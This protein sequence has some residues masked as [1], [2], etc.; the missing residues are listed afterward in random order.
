MKQ[1]R[2]TSD[3]S[4]FL[5]A[6]SRGRH[7]EVEWLDDIFGADENWES[8]RT[9]RKSILLEADSKPRR[10]RVT[11]GLSRESRELLEGIAPESPLVRRMLDSQPP[12]SRNSATRRS[13]RKASK[14]PQRILSP[15]DQLQDSAAVDIESDQNSSEGSSLGKFGRVIPR[16]DERGER[17]RRKLKRLRDQVRERRKQSGRKNRVAEYFID[18]TSHPSDLFET[19]GTQIS[20]QRNRRSRKQ[21]AQRKDRADA[22]S[23]TT[24]PEFSDDAS[25]IAGAYTVLQIDSDTK[26]E[27]ESYRDWF[28]RVIIRSRWITWFTTF[29][30]HWVLL[31]LLG[32]IIINVPEESGLGLLDGSFTPTEPH[33]LEPLEPEPFE[34]ELPPVDEVPEPLTPVAQLAPETFTEAITEIPTELSSVAA[35]T[36]A[37]ATEEHPESQT[38]RPSPPTPTSAV[39]AGSFSVWTEPSLPKA[40]EPYRIIIQIRLPEGVTKYSTSDLQGFVVG[41]DGYRKPIPGSNIMPLA[42]EDGYVRFVVPIVSADKQ[43]R[44]TIMIRSRLLKESQ[45]LLLEF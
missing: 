25:D 24:L 37:D 20:T 26:P 35:E 23:Q 44:D 34:I 2:N 13:T 39:S 14:N 27:T 4:L 7:G 21:A 17:R 42:V 22:E 19:T 36:I 29:Y 16:N 3:D 40:D 12:E 31:L 28:Q 10:R 30:V 32:A 5:A 43:V 11:S 9:T 8:L 45:E 6:R 33:L 38:R 1:Q 41:S 15:R 18:E